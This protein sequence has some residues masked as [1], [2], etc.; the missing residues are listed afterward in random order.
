MIRIMS[1]IFILSLITTL[2]AFADNQ[3]SLT[4]EV[5][6][7]K[8][9]DFEHSLPINLQSEINQKNAPIMMEIF[10]TCISYDR[11]SSFEV[12]SLVNQQGIVEK[13]WSNTQTI[14]GKCAA[15]TFIGKELLQIE[16]KKY[17]A[18]LEFTLHHK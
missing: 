13:T 18:I 11:P 8:A 17:Y 14:F 9:L 15:Q 12:V 16:K 2:S 10:K 4:Y 3:E 7:K 6:R 1:N 5:M